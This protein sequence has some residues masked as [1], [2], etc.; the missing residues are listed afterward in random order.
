[1]PVSGPVSAPARAT[2][3]KKSEAENRELKR[4]NEILLA[5]SSFLAWELD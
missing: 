3:I 2:R 5:A 1:M 4:A